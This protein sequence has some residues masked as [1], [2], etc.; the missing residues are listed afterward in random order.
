[1][2][3]KVLYFEGAGCDFTPTK[4]SDIGNHRIRTAFKNDEGKLV[5][6]ELSG[7]DVKDKKKTITHWKAHVDHA[8]YITDGNDDENMNRIS[9][10]WVYVRDN[11]KYTKEDVTKLVNKLC[12]ASF[13]T[14]EVLD[15]MEGY[16]VHGDYRTYNLMDNHVINPARTEARN[17]A[18]NEIDMKFRELLN[19]KYSKIGLVRMDDD[20]IT[21]KCHTYERDL[22]K[23]GLTDKNR[24]VTIPV[25]Y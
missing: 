17:K 19:E 5:Y 8:H 2:E 24:E 14:V 6:I 7:F 9:H 20:S 15:W 18:Y 4:L 25:K 13:D 22:Y 10:D 1:M 3:K 12:K 23:V 21:I 16:R 11:V